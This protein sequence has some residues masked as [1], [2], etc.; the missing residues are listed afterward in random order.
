[1]Y[2]SFV[3][4]WNNF[5]LYMY[6]YVVQ[7]HN[8][9]QKR[10]SLIQINRNAVY[11][12]YT[13]KNQK[14]RPSQQQILNLFFVIFNKDR[15]SKI[16]WNFHDSFSLLQVLIMSRLILWMLC[17]YFSCFSLPYMGHN[18]EK[19]GRKFHNYRKEWKIVLFLTNGLHFS[20]L[21]TVEII[22]AKL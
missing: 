6:I 7:H 1:M 10:L 18:T 14:T 21:S 13:K 20:M 2:E 12:R 16:K 8:S 4:I 19:N 11:Q 15:E 17:F 5:E 3:I 9:T 22:G